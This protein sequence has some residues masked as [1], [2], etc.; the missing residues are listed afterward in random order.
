[1]VSTQCTAA[2]AAEADAKAA[3]VKA[4]SDV[5]GAQIAAT[6][7]AASA[8]SHLRTVHATANKAYADAQAATALACA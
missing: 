6:A 8:F 5:H 1:M 7:T 4:A 3:E 2:M